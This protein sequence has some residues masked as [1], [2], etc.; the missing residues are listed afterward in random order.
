MS[1]AQII[2]EAEDKARD[3]EFAKAMHGQAA[4]ATGGIRSMLAKDKSTRDAQKASVDAYYQFWEKDRA[5][6]ETEEDKKKRLANYATL[7]RHYY[8]LA[9]DLYENG[10]GQSFRKC[11]LLTFCAKLQGNLKS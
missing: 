11:S 9:T 5:K 4:K 1:P 6:D 7:T 8:N 2:L 10:W 3:A